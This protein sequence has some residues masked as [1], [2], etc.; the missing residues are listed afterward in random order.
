MRASKVPSGKVWKSTRG[1]V[2]PPFEFRLCSLKAMTKWR[3]ALNQISKVMR[4]LTEWDI[5][6]E[7]KMKWVLNKLSTK[8]K[9][10][11]QVPWTLNESHSKHNGAV[12]NAFPKSCHMLMNQNQTSHWFSTVHWLAQNPSWVKRKTLRW[13]NKASEDRYSKF[14]DVPPSNFQ[15]HS[16]CFS[17]CGWWR[18]SDHNCKQCFSLGI[19]ASKTLQIESELQSQNSWSHR[20]FS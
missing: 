2:F 4:I 9:A 5:D 8:Q 14:D 10:P 1:Q 15:R 7:Q 11:L 20:T 6:A 17:I 13:N 12:R 18:T 3:R 16:S 19:L